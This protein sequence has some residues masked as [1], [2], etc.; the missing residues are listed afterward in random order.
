MFCFPFAAGSCFSYQPLIRQ[1]LP[2]RV[3]V[4][5]DYPGRG[6]RPFEPALTTLDAVVDD[7]FERLRTQLTGP[8]AFFGHSMGSLVAY[9]LSCRLRAEGMTP[10]QH[11]FLSGR[12]GAAIP[13]KQRNAQHMTRQEIIDE[14]REM[15]GDVSA[16]LKN[17]RLFDRYEQVLR[18]DMMALESYAYAATGPASLSTPVTVFI[19]DRD[20]YTPA[21]AARWQ[22]DFSRPIDLHVL[23][24][25]HFF[26]FDNGP[27]LHRCIDRALNPHLI[28]ITV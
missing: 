10:P 24:G 13:E 27:F 11:L 9:Q 6:R 5:L 19:G 3:W 17:P 20:L 14:V 26:L 7:L 15:D 18:A 2:G 8:F 22:E 4:P 12:G 25:G 21:E 23:P 1:A 28:D 16:L